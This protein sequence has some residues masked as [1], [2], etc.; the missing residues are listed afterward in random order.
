MCSDSIVDEPADPGA[1]HAADL[2]AVVRRLV[3]PGTRNR[4]RR[5]DERKLRE[6]VGA[7]RLASGEVIGRLELR[8]AAEAVLDPRLAGGP[9]LVQGRRAHAQRRDGADPGDRNPAHQDWRAD[10]NST[11]S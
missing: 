9:A 2:G 10:T 7:A 1:D 4:L 6:A 8:A 5:R 3:Q 11:T